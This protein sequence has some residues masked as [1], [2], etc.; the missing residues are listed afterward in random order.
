MK[1]LIKK[2]LVIIILFIVGVCKGQE[3]KAGILDHDKFSY[4]G[5]INKKI[6]VTLSLTILGDNTVFGEIKYL[7]AKN[8]APIKIIGVF[9]IEKE[10]VL[11]LCEFEKT[12]NIRG[13]IRGKLND[14][15]Q[16]LTGDWGSIKSDVTYPLNLNYKEHSTIKPTIVTTSNFEGEY[17]YHYGETGFDG[18]IKLTKEKSGTYAYAIGTVTGDKTKSIA[19]ASG[20]GLVIEDDE[21]VIEVNKT[22]RFKVTFYE[23]FLKISAMDEN[24]NSCGFTGVN[25]TLQGSYLKIKR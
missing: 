5:F 2:G 24:M 10:Y 23:G 8:P 14:H 17:A 11:M 20:T 1:V 18:V 12:G 3:K 7:K 19:T 16:K 25:A 6:P 22:C 9:N 15:E 4:S 21:C 13:I